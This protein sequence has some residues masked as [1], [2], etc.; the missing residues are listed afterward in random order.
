MVISDSRHT[1]CSN[2]TEARWTLSLQWL[3]GNSCT[4]A[5]DVR[6]YI[7]GTNEPKS[8]QECIVLI[9]LL[10]DLSTLC[11][12][13]HLWPLILCSLPRLLSTLWH[14]LLQSHCGDDR[15]G[16]LFSWWYVYISISIYLSIYLSF[17]YIYIYIYI[18]IYVCVSGTLSWDTKAVDCF[19]LHDGVPPIYDAPYVVKEQLSRYWSNIH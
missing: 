15:E 2:L 6:L 9:L 17:L 14:E 12:V 3:Y 8:I 5:H 1:E 18:Y 10:W 19:W 13:D 7:A 16:T 11:V 4:W